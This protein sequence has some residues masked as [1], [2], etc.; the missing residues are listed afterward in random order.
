[1]FQNPAIFFFCIL[2]SLLK[3]NA[4]IISVRI[5]YLRC[6]GR[7]LINCGTLDRSADIE[8]TSQHNFNVLNLSNYL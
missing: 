3:R 1:M 7:K 6:N 2:S 5:F 4:A 8:V